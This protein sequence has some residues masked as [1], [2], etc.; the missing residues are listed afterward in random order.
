MNTFHLAIFI[1]GIGKRTFVTLNPLW[2]YEE[3]CH[4]SMNMVLKEEEKNK[5][6]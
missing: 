1:K 6:R 4:I 2:C 5:Y 3:K